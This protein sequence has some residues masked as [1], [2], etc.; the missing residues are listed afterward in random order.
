VTRRKRSRGLVVLISIVFALLL[1]EGVLV[2]FV[3]VS[4]SAGDKLGKVAESVTRAWAGSGGEP[5]IRAKVAGAF[6]DGYESWIVPLWAEPTTPGGDPEFTA[7]VECHKDYATKRRF[8]VYMDHPL[9][10]QLGVA[11]ATCHPENAHPAPPHPQ[12]KVCATCHSEVQQK[13]ECGF[14]HPPASLPHF[15]LLGAPRD[16]VVECDVCHPRK[17]FEAA[18]AIPLVHGDFLGGDQGECLSC[19]EIS[20]CNECHQPPHPPG[21]VSTHGPQVGEN[22]AYCTTCH[23]DTWCSDSCHASTST[24]PLPQKPLPTVGVR[25]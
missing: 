16:A 7:C 10:A 24:N 22:P 21:W 5:G 13:N 6:H 1:A 8:S 4:P 14:C 23:T 17:T 3:F 12:E 20:S 19:H 18:A 9:H 11:C 25:P 2:A 15:Y